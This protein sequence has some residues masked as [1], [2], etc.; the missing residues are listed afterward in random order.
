MYE[1]LKSNSLPM[2]AADQLMVQKWHILMFEPV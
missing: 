2:D 1:R